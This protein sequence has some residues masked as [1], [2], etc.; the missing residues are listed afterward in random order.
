MRILYVEDNPRDADLAIR[1]LLKAAPDFRLESAATLAEAAARLERLDAEPL[2]LVL[3]DVRLP[4]GDGLALLKQIRDRALSLAVVVITGTGDEETAVA[5][6]KAGAD[7]YVT[8]RK[9]YLGRLPLVLESALRHYRASAVRRSRTLRVLYAERDPKDVDLTRRHFARHAGH[10]HV[11]AVSTGPEALQSLQAADGSAGYDVLLLDYRLPG[12]DA[13][14]LLKELRLVRKLDTPVV[15]VTGQGSEEVA[16]QATKLGAYGYVVKNPGYLYQLPGEL[17]NA[18]FR[19]E[20]TCR[21]KALRESEERRRLAQ[22]AARVGTWEW[23]VRTGESSWSEMI[24]ELVGLEPDDGVTTAERFIKFIHPE[25]RDRAVRKVT[26]VIDEGEVYYDEFRLIRRD[27]SVLW[28]SS[29]GRVIRSASGRP[30]R[31]LGVNID[32]TERKRVEE[33]LGQTQEMG[34]RIIESS[35][36]CIKVLDLDGRL[37][38]MNPN[39][40]KVLEICDINAYLHTPWLDFWEGEHREAAAQAIARAKAGERGGFRGYSPTAR[41]TPRWWDVVVTPITNLRGNVVQLLAVSR[42]ITEHKLAEEALKDSEERN[43]ATLEAIPDLMFLQNRE[44]VYLD[45]H[46]QNPHVLYVPPEQFIGKQL[47]D[48]LPP[49]LAAQFY[50][51]FERA[52]ATGETQVQEYSLPMPDGSRWYEARIARCNGERLLSIVRDITERRRAED[53]L[54]E[55]ENRVRLF[56]EHT[57]AAVA[58]FDREMRYLLTSRRWLKDNKL[59]EQDIIG[60]CHYDVVPDIPER[61]RE[62]HRRCL[63]GVV[64]CCEEDVFQHPD[65]TFDWVRWETRPWY[66]AGGE[67]GGIIMFSETITERKQAAEALR[68]SEERFAQAF[69]SNPQPMS[70]ATL[71]EGCYMDV[72]ES[73]LEMS[74]Y[75]RGEIVG[76]TSLELNVLETPAERAAFT[77]Q[78]KENGSIQNVETK[79]RTK[80]GA[81]RVLLSSSE[82]MEVEGRQCILTASSDITER[83]RAEEELLQ[84]TVRL[85]TLQDEERRRIARELHDGTAQNLFAMT[86]NLARLQQHAAAQDAELQQ[87]VS[88]TITLGDESLREIRTLSYLLHPPLLDQAGLVSALRWYVGGFMKRSGVY[89]DLISLQPIGRLSP[90]VETALFRIVQ[91][92]L[93]N[94]HRHS[95]GK[96]ASVRLEKKNGEVVLQIK[97]DGRGMPL[98]EGLNP[99]DDVQGLGV[100]ILGMRQRMRQL[101]GRLEVA[102][103]AGGT[104]VT[105]AVP[106]KEGD[107]RDTHPAG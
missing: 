106:F 3:T 17:E 6:L 82:L 33:T 13:L 8:K 46:T 107:E 31:V 95:G 48:V 25:D 34:R 74:G 2:D 58:M 57:P 104:T 1:Q 24:W 7:D 45:Y 84:L 11:D 42:D 100:G 102:S 105:A 9:D 18:L 67:I 86:F 30:E 94:I 78:L 22:Q 10:I 44:G 75:T 76:R 79:F 69:Q 63:A 98:T 66:M 83:K 64:E 92:G 51:C 90:E 73:F 77:R 47:R 35:N 16:L 26:E 4:D 52:L 12:L 43:R 28:V 80:G 15:L 99:A 71:D 97:D 62:G 29:K 101:G 39:G 68:A 81:F 23:D 93:T 59:G 60:R 88:D 85:F 40:Q 70:L 91:E 41:G 37:L 96:N 27:G 65:G 49:E 56:V 32:I 14:E 55:N 61:W 38:Y 20:L 36:D 5:A 87:L 21:E 19:S 53:A 54:R 103:G 89:V 72:N 50:E